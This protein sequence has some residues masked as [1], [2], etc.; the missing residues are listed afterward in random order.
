MAQQSPDWKSLFLEAQR[1]REAAES[2][3]KEEQRKREKIE[4]DTRYTTLPEFLDACHNYLYSGLTVQT[5]MTMSTRGD[6]TNANNKLRPE[7]LCLWEDFPDNRQL[8]G[9]ILWNLTLFRSGTL[10]RCMPW[11]TRA[12]ESGEG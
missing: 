10:T 8:F 4:E 7:R 1:E 5:N 2:A 9:A 3:Q 6:P 12:R 11:R